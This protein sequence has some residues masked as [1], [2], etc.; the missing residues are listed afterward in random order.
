MTASGRA[1]P[2]RVLRVAL[3]IALGAS[4]ALE[5]PGAAERAPVAVAPSEHWDYRLEPGDSLWSI[6]GRFL[7]SALW[8]QW[9]Q[10]VARV[11]RDGRG[12]WTDSLAFRRPTPGPA[13]DAPSV[14]ADVITL[15]WRAGGSGHTWRLQVSASPTFADTVIDARSDRPGHAMSRPAP[16]RY[17]L[18]VSTVEPDGMEGPF[19]PVQILDVPEPPPPPAPGHPTWPMLLPL[20]FLLFP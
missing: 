18:R 14:A 2:F 16:G 7:E 19:G 6:A 4:V 10:Q 5:T 3:P 9:L 8:W 15:S 20:L 17:Y 11:D 12:P 1:H 13:A